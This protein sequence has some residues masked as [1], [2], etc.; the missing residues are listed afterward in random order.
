[1]RRGEVWTAKLSPSRWRVVGKTRPVL[2]VQAD[3]LGAEVTPMVVV[4]QST[5]R[6]YPGFRLCRITVP[7]RGRMLAHCPIVVDQP[8][9]PDRAGIG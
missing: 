2:I 8:R 6:V 5:T 3:E 4:L 9:S 1:M 7:A